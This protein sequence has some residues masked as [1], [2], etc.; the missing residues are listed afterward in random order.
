MSAF[1]GENSFI[2]PADQLRG[3]FAD[4]REIIWIWGHEHRFSMYGKYQHPD[5]ANGLKYATAYGRCIGNGGM[6]DEHTSARK[7]DQQL[8]KDCNLVL[9][10][11]RTVDTVPYMLLFKNDIGANGYALLD[12]SDE[13]LSINYYSSYTNDENTDPVEQLIITETWTAD[14]QTGE[15]KCTATVDHTVGADGKSALCYADG[16]TLN[17]LGNA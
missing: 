13:T 17:D 4:D 3:I 16:K 2:N 8:A 10:D 5:G 9:W 1:G 15:I 7:V 14:N 12:L 11:Y 6:P